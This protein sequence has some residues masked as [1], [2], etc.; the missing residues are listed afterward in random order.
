MTTKR[1]L[2]QIKGI[3]EAKVDKIKEAI[4]KIVVSIVHWSIYMQVIRILYRTF[5]YIQYLKF[6]NFCANNNNRSLCDFSRILGPFANKENIL[7][8]FMYGRFFQFL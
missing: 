5:L 2:L 4:Q 1:K 7:T 8:S 6:R 3:S